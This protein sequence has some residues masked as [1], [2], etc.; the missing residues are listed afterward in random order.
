MASL[1]CIPFTVV[2]TCPELQLLSKSSACP[3]LYLIA[4]ST[5]FLMKSVSFLHAGK[6]QPH[7]H[8][9]AT[10]A[11]AH[12]AQANPDAMYGQQAPP[13]WWAA[14]AAAGGVSPLAALAHV[15]DQRSVRPYSTDN[16]LSCVLVKLQHLYKACEKKL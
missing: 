7:G 16:V 9:P 14:P 1:V 5:L 13:W 15:S 12:A 2:V 3:Y 8:R 4:A 11:A 6:A 10:L